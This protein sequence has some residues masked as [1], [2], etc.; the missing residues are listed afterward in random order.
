MWSD[1]GPWGLL[2]RSNGSLV[3]GC[4][5]MAKDHGYRESTV[6]GT[7]W[8]THS[9]LWS[10]RLSSLAEHHERET[11]HLPLVSEEASRRQGTGASGRGPSMAGVAWEAGG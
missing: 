7:A 11:R 5:L 6:I 9:Q 10:E 4:E 8:Y 1:G 2:S 3:E